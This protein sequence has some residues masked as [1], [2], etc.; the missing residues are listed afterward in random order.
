MIIMMMMMSMSTMMM[1]LAVLMAM[2]LLVWQGFKALR[3]GLIADTFLEA[4]DVH[5]HRKTYEEFE[6]R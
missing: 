1:M 6:L 3:A 2:M 5:R 4:M